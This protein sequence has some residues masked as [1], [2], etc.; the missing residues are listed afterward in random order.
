[1]KL[2]AAILSAILIGP[3]QGDESLIYSYD[4]VDAVLADAEN[5][6]FNIADGKIS[7]MDQ[8]ILAKQIGLLG[9]IRTTIGVTGY[10][11]QSNFKLGYWSAYND[12]FKK[13]HQEN[14]FYKVESGN[15]DRDKYVQSI[16]RWNRYFIKN[17]EENLPEFEALMASGGIVGQADKARFL[18]ASLYYGNIGR[19]YNNSED[20]Q[21]LLEKWPTF[22]WPICTVGPQSQFD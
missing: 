15:Y 3:A 20:P 16:S 19:L 7:A 14:P 6:A 1:M 8:I 10:D 17:W 12:V 2:Y 11:T 18:A 13:S 4:S 5:I 22:I 21:D 9:E